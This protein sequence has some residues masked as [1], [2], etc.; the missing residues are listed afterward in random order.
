[1]AIM[2]ARRLPLSA[3]LSQPLVAFIIEFD[4]E[5]EHR[6]PHRTT[7]YGKTPGSPR[8][9]W[10]VSM[11]MWE[12]CMRCVP[13]Q[14]ISVRALEC[15]VRAR[16]NWNGMLRWKYIWLEP[17]PEDPRPKP[18]QSALIVRPTAAGRMAQQIW[19][20][21]TS[22]I[23]SRWSERF[24][25]A[26]VDRL[27][28]ALQTIS[29]RLD[30]AL[31]NCLPI[32]KYGLFNQLLDLRR[33]G[34]VTPDPSAS[35]PALPQLLSR[36]LLAF[37]LEFETDSPLALAIGANVLRIVQADAL[38]VRDLPARSGV[39]KPGLAMAV[40]FLTN[41]GYATVQPEARG[42]RVQVLILSPKGVQ[43][44]DQYQRRLAA[45]ERN[46][47]ERFGAADIERLRTALQEVIGTSP[48]SALFRGLE[49]WPE[50]W[51]ARVG[52]PLTL[53][54]FPMILHRGGFPD[55]S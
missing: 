40:K 52:R 43:A 55:G 31:P 49:P 11:V 39:A 32:L 18:P 5:A 9:L 44:H 41:H 24:G 30:P 13:E 6:I 45:V 15:L 29:S 46:W 14:G 34:S 27:R 7:S 26:V 12:N 28:H 51:R 17:A 48:D 3:L 36:V 23:E 1:M 22:E 2:A 10:L 4:N 20:P 37:A 53:P 54:H 38:R 16:T 19:R 50:G 21:L 33:C 47:E 35:K 8:A 42:S 25:P